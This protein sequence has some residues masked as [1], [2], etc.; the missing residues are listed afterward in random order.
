MLS[1][2]EARENMSSRPSGIGETET[3][4]LLV[5]MRYNYRRRMRVGCLLFAFLSRAFPLPPGHISLPHPSHLLDGRKQHHNPEQTSSLSQPQCLFCPTSSSP[6]PSPE[7]NILGIAAGGMCAHNGLAPNGDGHTEWAAV[8]RYVRRY[9]AGMGIPSCPHIKGLLV[10]TSTEGN[11]ICAP[12]SEAQES[13]RHH[14]KAT[15]E[16]PGVMAWHG[17]EFSPSNNIYLGHSNVS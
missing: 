17:I 8:A 1:R 15:L 14:H 13:C 11:R 3:E 7:G 9:G 10:S 5:A 4:M 6:L 2:P 16:S 12:P